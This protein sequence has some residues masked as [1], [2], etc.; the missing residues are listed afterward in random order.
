MEIRTCHTQVQIPKWSQLW[1]PPFIVLF[2]VFS[3]SPRA[4]ERAYGWLFK[5][6]YHVE[7]LEYK[8]YWWYMSVFTFLKKK[9]THCIY[10]S[11]RHWR[12]FQIQTLHQ[13]LTDSIGLNLCQQDIMC[14]KWSPGY[15]IKSQFSHWV[16]KITTNYVII[17]KSHLNSLNFKFFIC[18]MGLIMLTLQSYCKD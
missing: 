10:I 16:S 18:T 11:F 2:P 8:R 1:C 13:C 15:K 9:N 6:M 17:F 3:S 5:K 7:K 4:W 12:N 14:S